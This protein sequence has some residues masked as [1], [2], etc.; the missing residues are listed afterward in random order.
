LGLRHLPRQTAARSLIHA[1]QENKDHFFRGWGTGNEQL[2]F[3]CHVELTDAT[4]KEK[5]NPALCQPQNNRH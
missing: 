2:N 3:S 5:E 4:I 1:Y